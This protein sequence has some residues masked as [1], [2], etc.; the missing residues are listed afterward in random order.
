MLIDQVED[1]VPVGRTYRH[2]P[3]I[4]GVVRTDRGLPGEWLDVEFTG[5][6]GHDMEAVVT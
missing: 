3:E 6:F 1:G 4:D 5:A 2:A